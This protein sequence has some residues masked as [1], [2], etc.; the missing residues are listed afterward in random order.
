MTMLSNNRQDAQRQER[1][2]GK[3]ANLAKLPAVVSRLFSIVIVIIAFIII[4][5]NT[6]IVPQLSKPD[7]R[8]RRAA[9]TRVQQLSRS[10]P[11]SWPNNTLHLVT[12][13]PHVPPFTTV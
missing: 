5:K 10:G 1:V 2:I 9:G 8:Q 12:R 7:G 6:I 13:A 11:S 3:T 4:E